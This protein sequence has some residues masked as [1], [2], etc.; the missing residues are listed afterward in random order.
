MQVKR[1]SLVALISA[2]LDHRV[3]AS[4]AGS[5]CTGTGAAGAGSDC[6]GAEAA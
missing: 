5:D 3:A 4:A 2:A 6:T 1:S